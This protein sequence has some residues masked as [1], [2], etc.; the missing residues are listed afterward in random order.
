MNVI[1]Q[2]VQYRGKGPDAVY[3]GADTRS[4]G[5]NLKVK[6]KQQFATLVRFKFCSKLNPN[7][8]HVK[9]GFR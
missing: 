6:T 4:K 7:T 9:H 2:T 3:G 5:V 8:P 1:V